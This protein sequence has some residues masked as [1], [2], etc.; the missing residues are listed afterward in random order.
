[1]R[2]DWNTPV[3]SLK[4][5]GPVRRG[6]LEAAGLATVGDLLLHLPRTYQDRRFRT[7]VSRVLAAETDETGAGSGALGREVTLR[8]RLSHLGAIRT[9]RRGLTLVRGRLDDGT[10]VLPVIW[11]NR[12]YLTRQIPDGAEVLLHGKVRE[13]RGG[14]VELL[15]PHLE[16]LSADA[17]PEETDDKNDEKNG[18]EDLEEPEVSQALVPVYPSA[19]SC[20]PAF[21]AGLIRQAL[22]RFDPRRTLHD[23]LPP[24]LLQRHGLPPLG[25]A[26]HRVHR[27]PSRFEAEDDVEAFLTRD[28]PAHRRLIYGELLEL[29]LRVGLARARQAEIRQSFRIRVDDR[30]HE[31][32]RRLLPFRLTGAQRRALK[33]I[34]EDMTRPRPMLRL[35]QGDVG[36]GKTVVAALALTVAMEN[37]LQGA[38]MAPTE[39][40][41]EQHFASLRRLFG[42]R[43]RIG[44]LTGS[45]EDREALEADLAAGRIQLAV[46]THALFQHGVRFRRLG[47]AV[48]DEQH[49]FGVEQRRR[50][51]EKG[52]HADILVM[53]ATP[54][55]RSLALT[56]Y[57]DLDLSV[58]DELP[59]GRT[60]VTTEVVPV[61]KRRGVYR[62]LA[63]ELADDGRAYVVFPLI[64]D[65]DRVAAEALERRGDEVRARL[66]AIP[67]TVVHGRLSREERDA[68][69]RAFARGE[70][71]LLVATTVIEVGVDVPE[72]TWMVIESAERFGL[73]QLHQLRGRVGRGDRPSRCVALHGRLSEDGRRRLEVFARTTDGFEIAEE[74]LAL[75]GP[76]ELLGTRQAGLPVF[77]T[78]DLLRDHRW[79]LRARDDAR[80]L[81]ARLGDPEL[82]ALRRR[83]ES[84]SPAGGGWRI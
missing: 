38:L 3:D 36:S 27:P 51:Q 6:E 33:E 78:A 48:I 82:A 25:E 23:P 17:D 61:G 59:P 44:L 28:S 10:G 2:L 50:L 18:G 13:A 71:R 52:L 62:R 5:V 14:G 11:F 60:P 40:L 41:A 58:L 20:G 55:P 57:G 65:S 81:L 26:L 32:C 74:D 24:A 4:G 70:V 69:M 49:R 79:L 39:L 16:R 42:D 53:T 7:P 35:L 83:I 64:E 54:I 66:S 84:R 22:E 37:G 67:S 30:V 56:A 15:N 12:P 19:G 46:G 76:G 72:A 80:E 34:V 1:M 9:R 75:R 68:A 73:A 45:V 31:A 77:R 63:G 47:L 29:Q 21:L 8:G 43:Y